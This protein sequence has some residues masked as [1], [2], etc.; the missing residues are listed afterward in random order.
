MQSGSGETLDI[1][2]ALLDMLTEC[3]PYV[4]S[5]VEL[6]KHVAKGLLLLA[7]ARRDCRSICGLQDI[8]SEFDSTVS[9]YDDDSVNLKLENHKG[10]D[11][12]LFCGLPPLALK[13]SREQFR[14]ALGTIIKLAQHARTIHTVVQGIEIGTE[15][16]AFSH[17]ECESN[18]P[19]ESVGPSQATLRNRSASTRA[20][21]K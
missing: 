13:Q 5:Q 9:V 20:L 8:R 1:D 12:Q 7:R 6:A 14:L 15:I 19:E 18:V 17:S 16:P 3:D 2:S 4:E 11:V 10:D 21:I